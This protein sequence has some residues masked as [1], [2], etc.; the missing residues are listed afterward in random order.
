[1]PDIDTGIITGWFSP[2]LK[3]HRDLAIELL[4]KHRSIT[5]SLL[6]RI[7]D[8]VQQTWPKFPPLDKVCYLNYW[9]RTELIRREFIGDTETALEKIVIVPMY[10]WNN[11]VLFNG[12]FFPVQRSWYF[13]KGDCRWVTRQIL[14]R[15]ESVNILDPPTNFLNEEQVTRLLLKKGYP[16]AYLTKQVVD[17]LERMHID[18]RLEELFQDS[19]SP[20]KNRQ[21][22]SMSGGMNFYGPVH[23]TG[24]IVNIEGNQYNFQQDSKDKVLN[25][26][27]QVVLAGLAGS[28]ISHLVN[29]V[30]PSLEA[31]GDVSKEEIAEAVKSTLAVQIPPQT[32]DGALEEVINQLLLG[33]S[34]SMLAEAI[35]EGIKLY[36]GS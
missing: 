13:V 8:P 33:A 29:Q 27:S 36:L 1:M 5:F 15:G 12:T 21:E 2:F 20:A 35:I 9:D 14:D 31:R 11:D 34:G 22:V 19:H 3:W 7:E 28:D 17:Y 6:T 24:N 26:V 18:L 25:G 23:V 32:N 10:V 4:D 30:S 16:G